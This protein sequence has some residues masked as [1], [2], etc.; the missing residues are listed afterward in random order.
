[1]ADTGYIENQLDY[2]ADDYIGPVGGR[3]AFSFDVTTALFFGRSPQRP[4]RSLGVVQPRLE[5]AGSER[6][7]H[8]YLVKDALVE[9][10][11]SNMS[12]FDRDRLLSWWRD[13]ARGMANPFTYIDGAV[14]AQVR[15]A[16][17]KL[18]EIRERAYDV[19]AVKLSLRVQ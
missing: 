9:L 17:P 2:V 16:T 12:R 13:T 18:P 15:F 8:D 10:E 7:V 4:G 19:Y 3:V 1:M 11:W 5:T 14:S 6:T